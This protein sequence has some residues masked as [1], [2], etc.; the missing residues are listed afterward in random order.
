MEIVAL[1]VGGVIALA[2]FFA[3][4]EIWCWY[5]KIND[6]LAELRALR[7]EIIA[8]RGQ[9]MPRPQQQLPPST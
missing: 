4:R 6:G 9:L 7:G 3:T 8:L 1:V 5:W 2:V